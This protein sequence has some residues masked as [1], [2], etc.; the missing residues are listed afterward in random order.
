MLAKVPGLQVAAV[1]SRNETVLWTVCFI[2]E[3]TRAARGMC[4]RIVDTGAAMGVRIFD[5]HIGF[6]PENESDPAFAAVRDIVRRL[7]D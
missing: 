1:M 7:C 4:Q 2:P 5:C 3:A 6:V